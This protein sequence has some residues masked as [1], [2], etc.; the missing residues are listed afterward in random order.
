MSGRPIGEQTGTQND[1]WYI[2]S[3]PDEITLYPYQEIATTDD[4]T[5][6]AALIPAFDTDPAQQTLPRQILLKY[7]DAIE[8]GFLA[9]LYAHPNKPYSAPLVAGQHRQAFIKAMGFYAAQ[10]KTGYNG[11]PNWRYPRTWKVSRTR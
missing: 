3:N 1:A 10:R 6:K 11:T 5:V 2:S 8:A 4:L 9:R 7:Y